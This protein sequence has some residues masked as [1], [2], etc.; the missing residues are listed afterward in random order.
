MPYPV[1]FGLPPF[2]RCRLLLGMSRWLTVA[3]IVLLAPAALQAQYPRARRGQFEV[4]GLDFRKDGGWRVRAASSPSAIHLLVR[5]R[6]LWG[7][8]EARPTPAAGPSIPGRKVH[9]LGA[10]AFRE[11]PPPLTPRPRSQ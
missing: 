4:S 5:G 7:L 1:T 6:D 2:Y 3:C 11:E 9:P 8:E 10:C